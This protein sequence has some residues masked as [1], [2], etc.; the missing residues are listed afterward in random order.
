MPM[1]GIEQPARLEINEDLRLRRFDT[2]DELALSWYQD[3]DLVKLV[4]GV[5]QPYSPEK[6]ERMYRYLG[7]VGELY[8]IE[9][10]VDGHFL[11]IGDVCFWQND[12]PIVISRPYWKQGIGKQVIGRLL[13]RAKELGWTQCEVNEIYFYNIGSQKLFESCGFRCYEESKDGKR[14]RICF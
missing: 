3:V 4:D 10:R 11:P 14:Y 6:L 7:G 5:D 1:Q 13:L 9:K 12:M 2:A 8:W